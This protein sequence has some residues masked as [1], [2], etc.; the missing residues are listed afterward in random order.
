MG[1]VDVI[2]VDV[3]NTGELVLRVADLALGMD[4][5]MRVI[6][7]DTT[8]VLADIDLA[9]NA[10]PNGYLFFRID[11]NAGDTVYAEVSDV[12]GSVGG[13]YSISGGP[14][15]P[16][17]VLSVSIDIKPGSDPNC[18]NNDGNGVIPVAI[19]GSSSFDVTTVDAETVELEGPP[20]RVVGKSNKLVASIEDVNSDGFNDLVVRIEDEDGVFSLGETIATLTGA[21]LEGTLRGTRTK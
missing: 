20:V 14:P 12:N 10:S 13:F 6:E 5:R 7:A 21:L 8:T 3:D 17:D 4:P 16:S 9:S 18:F 15:F 2:R 1:D 11:V 19:L